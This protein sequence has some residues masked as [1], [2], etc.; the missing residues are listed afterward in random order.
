VARLG[1]GPS[2]VFVTVHLCYVSRSQPAGDDKGHYALCHLMPFV[3]IVDKEPTAA[4]AASSSSAA[5]IQPSR[6]GK[7]LRMKSGAFGEISLHSGRYLRDCPYICCEY[8]YD[9]RWFEDGEC[10]ILD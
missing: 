7:E 10:K 3:T 9:A 1:V 8:M 5:A 4:P 2:G 6:K